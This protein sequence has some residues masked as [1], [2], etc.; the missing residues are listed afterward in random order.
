[1]RLKDEI[2][3]SR[4]FGGLTFGPGDG[5][6][7][8]MSDLK[9]SAKNANEITI[10]SGYFSSSFVIDL[11]KVSSSKGKCKV[12]L[13]FGYDRI[14]DM[15]Y[16]ERRVREIKDELRKMG[17]RKK[18]I[19]AHVVKDV[20][21]LHTKLFGFLRATS[22]IWY[23]GSANASE[24]I[25]GDRHELMVKL[26]GKSDSLNRYVEEISSLCIPETS[27][28][29]LD[30]TGFWA[31]GYL[32]Y[33]P[34]R[35]VRFTFD[36]FR[37]PNDSRRQ[38]SRVL[39]QATDVPF[40][41]LTVEGFGFNLLDALGVDTVNDDSVPV[42]RL[43]F[44]HYCVETEIGY[45]M[46]QRYLDDLHRSLDKS[47]KQEKKRLTKIGEKFRRIDCDNLQKELEDKFEQYVNDS[48]KMFV[49]NKIEFHELP[50]LK[51]RFSQFVSSCKKRLDDEK[52]VDRM[53]KKLA[54]GKMPNIGGDQS[55][56]EAFRES[57]Y[58]GISDAMTMSKTKIRIC[59]DL[60]KELDLNDTDQYDVK[61]LRS[62]ICKKLE[63]GWKF[64][65]K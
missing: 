23:V 60:I 11:L 21:P 37:I 22:R 10:I 28:G 35:E 51:E 62:I 63:G 1:M 59:A 5:V 4:E 14:G 12:R 58:L 9:S 32:I 50:D 13:I 36:A 61:Q 57:F 25:Q 34:S 6:N 18:N 39:A 8:L 38:L 65:H 26:Y 55:A 24:A 53:S 44:R 47:E 46:P 3:L 64:S 54:Y 56:V 33:K 43:K 30:E 17:Y 31:T 15:A 42:S 7:C 45:W 2:F 49:E 29:A 16:N 27:S 19:F 20:V 41:D 48:E 52:W 40:S